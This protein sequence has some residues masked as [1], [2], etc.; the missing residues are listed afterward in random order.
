LHYTTGSAV[1]KTPPIV[2]WLVTW[3]GLMVENSTIAIKY[4]YKQINPMTTVS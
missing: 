2:L 1:I 4:K 3:L